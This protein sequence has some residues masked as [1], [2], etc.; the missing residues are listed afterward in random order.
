[1]YYSTMTQKDVI[2][3][4]KNMRKEKAT[5]KQIVKHAKTIAYSPSESVIR[6]QI[7]AL[8]KNNI[9]KYNSIDKTYSFV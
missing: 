8:V 7:C 9:L 4:I 3:I 5:S 2:N 6:K 1:M